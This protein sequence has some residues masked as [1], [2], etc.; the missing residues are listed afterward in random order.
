V[1][2]PLGRD[3]RL[4]ATVLRIKGGE[5]GVQPWPFLGIAESLKHLSHQALDSWNVSSLAMKPT[6]DRW[7][8]PRKSYQYPDRRRGRDTTVNNG[9]SRCPTDNQN[10]QL[11]SRNRP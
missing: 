2:L 6:M 10:P 5:E 1:L 11:V 3:S 7:S 4:L 9:Q 8:W